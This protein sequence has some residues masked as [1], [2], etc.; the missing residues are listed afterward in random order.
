MKKPLRS[1]FKLLFTVNGTFTCK[2]QKNQFSNGFQFV[3]EI[4]SRNL[5]FVSGGSNEDDELQAA[6]LASLENDEVIAVSLKVLERKMMI[7]SIS[8]LNAARDKKK[9]ESFQFTW[10]K[11]KNRRLYGETGFVY[12]Q[13]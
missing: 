3:W 6:I 13:K 7:F 11:K 4:E 12:S 8:S 2:Q 5:K 1:K 10:D 9:I